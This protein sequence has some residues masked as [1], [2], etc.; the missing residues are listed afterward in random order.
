MFDN[1]EKIYI[2]NN[3]GARKYA[4]IVIPIIISIIIVMIISYIMKKV[5]FLYIASF[6]FIVLMFLLKIT[7]YLKIVNPKGL[8]ELI[9]LK[10]KYDSILYEKTKKSIKKVL[11]ER[12]NYNV[13]SINI[14][15]SYYKDL[16]PSKN[17]DISNVINYVFS[18]LSAFGVLVT[19]ENTEMINAIYITILCIAIMIGIFF[20]TNKVL[21]KLFEGILNNKI[22]TKQVY[23]TLVDIYLE[24]VGNNK[25]KSKRKFANNKVSR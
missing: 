14:L 22:N 17:F 7:I 12:N 21:D 10:T 19:I 16:K 23:K 4:K 1:I 2:M 5:A 13:D 6:C 20:A 9:F 8:I 25:I 24:L 11:K 15:I 3:S 18:F